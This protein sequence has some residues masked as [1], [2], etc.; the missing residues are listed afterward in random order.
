MQRTLLTVAFALVAAFSSAQSDPCQSLIGSPYYACKHPVAQDVVV[1]LAGSGLDKPISTSTVNRQALTRIQVVQSDGHKTGV[2][3]FHQSFISNLTVNG[4]D[5]KQY[6]IRCAAHVEWQH[7]ISPTE[8]FATPATLENGDTVWI[9]YRDSNDHNKPSRAKYDII[10]SEEST[11]PFTEANPVEIMK[12]SQEWSI[13]AR[14]VV[15]VTTAKNQ[16]EK[17]TVTAVRVATFEEW[18]AEYTKKGLTPNPQ[19]LAS[20]RLPSA[21]FYEVNSWSR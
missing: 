2:P 21:R 4:N 6:V 16:V 5:G 15:N 10:K 18:L 3:L 17:Q 14:Y 13:G 7:C 8:G 19:Q 11:V 12:V 9:F 1:G 20:S